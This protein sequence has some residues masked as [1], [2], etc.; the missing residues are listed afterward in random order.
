LE[1]LLVPLVTPLNE[2]TLLVL[3]Q[4]DPTQVHDGYFQEYKL[5]I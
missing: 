5:Q 1:P 2:L 4:F 3:V